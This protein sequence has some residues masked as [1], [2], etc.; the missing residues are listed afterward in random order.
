MQIYD[1]TKWQKIFL[2]RS[3]PVRGYHR[4][5]P[6]LVRFYSAGPVRSDVHV[7]HRTNSQHVSQR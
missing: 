7:C 3:D 6:V 5:G 4:S 1:L 2:V